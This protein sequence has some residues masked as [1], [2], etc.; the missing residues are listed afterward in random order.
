MDVKHASS[1]KRL[2]V[3]IRAVLRYPRK[4]SV[5]YYN[6]APLRASSLEISKFKLKFI[7]SLN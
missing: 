7:N 4:N 6:V 2:E 5:L 3:V 1:W